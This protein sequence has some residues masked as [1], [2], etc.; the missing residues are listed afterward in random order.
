MKAEC[1]I[2]MNELTSIVD[3]MLAEKNKTGRE[4]FQHMTGN[5]PLAENEG[6][7]FYPFIEEIFDIIKRNGFGEDAKGQLV[8]LLGSMFEG[9]P[10]NEEDYDRDRDARNAGFRNAAE[11]DA[12]NWS[13]GTEEDE[14]PIEPWRL[15]NRRV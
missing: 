1:K 3:S 4:A 5:A 9:E 15:K 7:E 11:A 6:S 10:L 14:R 12:L 2:N 13:Q 8:E